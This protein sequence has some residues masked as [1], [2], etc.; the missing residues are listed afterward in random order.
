MEINAS[1]DNINSVKYNVHE[2]Q[3]YR[4]WYHFQPL[5]NWMNDPNGML[6]NFS[7]FQLN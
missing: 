1:P 7:D 5:Q 6:V 4:T 3:P 2:K